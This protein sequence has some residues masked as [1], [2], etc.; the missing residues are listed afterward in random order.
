MKSNFTLLIL[1]TAL[2]LLSVG[3][4]FG[5][6][7]A[8]HNGELFEFEMVFLQNSVMRMELSSPHVSDQMGV[9][10]VLPLQHSGYIP[11]A[12]LAFGLND[13]FPATGPFTVPKDPIPSTKDKWE[14]PT[15]TKDEEKQAKKDYDEY[16]DLTSVKKGSA[17]QKEKDP[18][19]KKK[20]ELERIAKLIKL[21]KEWD[22]NWGTDKNGVTRH[23]NEIDA[24]KRE[25]NKKYG[26]WIDSHGNATQQKEHED[27]KKEQDECWKNEAG[28][29]SSTPT[30]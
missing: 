17:E 27:W 19:K 15:R 18:Q 30:K 10:E 24:R 29:T 12:F 16:K 14:K 20:L 23:D 28:G 9:L 7:D 4:A 22:E 6:S 26:E 21:M 25:Y 8:Q 2:A 5:Q 3:T 1:S 13:K 11:S